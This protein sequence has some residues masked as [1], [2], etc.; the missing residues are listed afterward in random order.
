MGIW[1]QVA[2]IVAVSSGAFDEVQPEKITEAKQALLA[3]LWKEAKK[4]MQT[5]NKGGKPTDELM[6][7][8]TDTAR[9]VSK[10]YEGA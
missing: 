7:L 2:S 3:K 4:D 9:A 5:L 10:A 1:E 6:Q 8:L